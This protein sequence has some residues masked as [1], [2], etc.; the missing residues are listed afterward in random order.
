MHLKQM[1][2]NSNSRFHLLSD[3]MMTGFVQA[4][5]V[6]TEGGGVQRFV[7]YSSQCSSIKVEVGTKE[8]VM[9]QYKVFL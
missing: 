6:C 1:Q 4:V 9:W 3:D 8:N 2:K 7:V 5:V